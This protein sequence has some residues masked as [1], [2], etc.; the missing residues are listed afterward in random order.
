MN[1]T[2]EQSLAVLD[3]NTQGTANVIVNRVT[4]ESDGESSKT[5][6]TTPSTTQV[7]NQDSNVADQAVVAQQEVANVVAKP[8]SVNTQTA[9]RTKRPTISFQSAR[10]IR[11]TS[12]FKALEIAN[13]DTDCIM[14]SIDN[15]R[16]L[17]ALTF[18]NCTFSKGEVKNYDAAVATLGAILNNAIADAQDATREQELQALKTACKAACSADHA[19]LKAHIT[20]QSKRYN[21]T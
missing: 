8:V 6:A 20:L 11:P 5:T 18:T 2:L 16:V 17:I 3:N 14:Q 13:V 10:A 21:I 19:A 7:I 9:N 1:K 4:V 12:K 15:Q